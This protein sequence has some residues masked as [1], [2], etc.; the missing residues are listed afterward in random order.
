MIKEGVSQQQHQLERR[1]YQR[2]P[3]GNA[4]PRRKEELLGR[5]FMVK[6]YMQRDNA[7]N[8]I[9]LLRF[10]FGCVVEFIYCKLLERADQ[11]EARSGDEIMME[12]LR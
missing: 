11:L 4:K 7:G 10:R 1:E 5:K 6:K 3:H 12:K 2:H 8:I 9:N